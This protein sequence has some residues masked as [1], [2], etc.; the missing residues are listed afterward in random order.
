MSGY[1]NDATL[2]HSEHVGGQSKKLPSKPYIPEFGRKSSPTLKQNTCN[3]VRP[4]DFP[5][6]SEAPLFQLNPQ[7]HLGNVEASSTHRKTASHCLHRMSSQKDTEPLK[8]ENHSYLFSFRAF[9]LVDLLRKRS[10]IFQGRHEDGC[11][12]DPWF[13]SWGLIIR[14]ELAL[15][16]HKTANIPRKA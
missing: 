3:L 10:P 13:N 4:P 1:A 14:C 8:R 2:E 6:T 16:T 5:P 15:A 11:T 12:A 9:D 7:T